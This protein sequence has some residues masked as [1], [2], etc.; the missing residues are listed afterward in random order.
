MLSHTVEYALRA[1][2][3]VART[4]PQA[5]PVNDI[6]DGID[7]P[8]GYLAKILGDLARAGILESSRGPGGGFRIA[9]HPNALALADIV[10]AIDGT[11][12]RR[13]LL[14]QGRCGDNPGCTAHTRW[15]PIANEMAAFFGKTTLADLLHQ[16]Q[17]LTEEANS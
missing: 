14:G 15:A 6:A 11:E 5:M 1:T 12:E 10:Q 4:H 7:A 8:R 9:S 2:L 13:C 3:F 16:P 17:R